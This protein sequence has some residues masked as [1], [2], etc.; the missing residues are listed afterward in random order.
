MSDAPLPDLSIEDELKKLREAIDALRLEMVTRAELEK[1]QAALLSPEDIRTMIENRLA[2]VRQEFQ[3][4]IDKESDVWMTNLDSLKNTLVKNF[5]DW[6]DQFKNQLNGVLTTIGAQ[7]SSVDQFGKVVTQLS[8]EVST[9]IKAS[10]AVIKSVNERQDR[11]RGFIDGITK[12]VDG[13][14]LNTTHDHKMLFGDPTSP[15]APPSLWKRME[16]LENAI[17]GLPALM[18]ER[19]APFQKVISHVESQ[20]A[21]QAR[22]EEVFQFVRA[23]ATSKQGIAIITASASGI[24]V[25]IEFVRALMTR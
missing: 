13:L 5:H 7:S 2:N 1:L 8:I 10:E 4:R 20:Q 24:S 18:A 15:D 21:A 17:N 11:H 12:R 6:R 9:Y 22:R 14:E 16:K 23:F 3:A 19:L 25:L